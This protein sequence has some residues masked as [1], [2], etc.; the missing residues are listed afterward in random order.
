MK[1]PKAIPTKAIPLLVALLGLSAGAQAYTWSNVA[2]GGGGMVTGVFPSKT[3]QGLVYARTDVG[4]A[5]RY[6]KA[7]AR[8]IPLQDWSSE[9]EKG[10]LGVESLAIDPKDGKHIVMLCGTDYFNNGRTAILRS[11]DGGTYFSVTDVTS[12]FKAHGNSMGRGTGEKLII[13]PGTSSVMYVGSRAN[14]LFKST[15]WG[16][17]WSQV[18]SLPVSTT[19]NG[20]GISFVQADPASVSGGVAQR[21]FVG[22]SRPDS[23]INF[24]RSNNA[25]GSF[26]AIAGGPSNMMPQRAVFDGAGN[27]I[28]T[29]ANGAG[30]GFN[31][32]PYDAGKIYKFN[33]NANSWTNITPNITS[34]FSGISVAN[35]NSQRLV[36]STINQYLWQN[37][38]WGDHVF[39]SNNGGTSWT[40]VTAR[41]FALNPDGVTWLGAGQAIHATASVAF[42]P[43]DSKAV[44]IT[45]GNGLFKTDNIDLTTT[46][47]R[48][49]VKGIEE[50]VPS[51]LF[52]IPGGAVVTTIGDFDGFLHSDV[53]AYGLQHTPPMGSTSSITFAAANST[54]MVRVGSKMYYSWSGGNSWTETTM[55]G[56]FGQV[57]LSPNGGTLLHAP[58]NS[59]TSYR[60]WNMGANWAAI[61][62][63]NSSNLS[64]SADG[65]NSNKFYAYERSAGTMF[66]SNDGG[67]SFTTGGN[68]GQWGGKLMRA[69]PG[70]EGDIWVPL[71][72][73]GLSRS[74]N[75]GASF[76]KITSVS[77]CNAI[78]FGKADVNASYPTVFIWGTVGGVRGIFRS[79]NTGASWVRV[80]DD[81][82]EFGGTGNAEFVNGDMNTFGVV[83]MSTVGRGAV[84]GKP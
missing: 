61:S 42:D 15:N 53:A 57:V 67:A 9:N 47:W 28:I 33:I 78:G 11:T 17:N 44:W 84:Y 60:S 31:G 22:V 83:Y 79:T 23:T 14:G 52:S 55:N 41:G 12:Q 26:T 66:V 45:S 19:P 37:G 34:A 29:F 76:S 54:A 69:A 43:Y 65:L 38:A 3:E 21:L 51:S 56:N 58:Q 36:T 35:G 5:Y 70:R 80:N 50:A 64:L 39:I 46:T 48:A 72:G 32:E 6:D 71:N 59:T 74:T 49:D 62:G 16:Y 13:D 18:T 82:H 27:L 73:G 7:A 40:D 81:A 25:G 77:D 8:W 24:Y 1:K 20:N 10:L 63:L 75:S 2:I 30:A 4:G 68:A